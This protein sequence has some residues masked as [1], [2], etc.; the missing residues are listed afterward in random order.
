MLKGLD[1]R[2]RRDSGG[3]HWHRATDR[4]TQI[5]SSGSRGRLQWILHCTFQSYRMVAEERTSCPDLTIPKV[6]VFEEVGKG[7]RVTLR[8]E[9]LAD[10]SF[11][12]A[13]T[14]I[15]ESRSKSTYI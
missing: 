7:E 12:G 6:M 13:L 8:I 10:S 15:N 14:G 1:E 9:S 5:R 4:G 11:V 2:V 3:N